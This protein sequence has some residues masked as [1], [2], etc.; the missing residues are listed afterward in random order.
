MDSKIIA[1]L[2]KNHIL[3][4][5]LGE[6]YAASCFYCFDEEE[7]ALLFASEESTHHMELI[8]R[9][10]RVA[11]TIHLCE[12]EIAKIQGVQFRGV[13]SGATQKQKE[14]Y[15]RHFPFAKVLKPKIWAIKLQW[16]KMTDNTL[17]FKTKIEWSI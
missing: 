12:R 13:V 2:K 9:D 11:G 8:K 4:L 10:P 16:I 1:F 3:T 7:Q 6:P 15:F 14:C 17:G 5:A